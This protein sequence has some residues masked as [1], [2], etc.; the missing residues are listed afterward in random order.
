MPTFEVVSYPSGVV[1]ARL[2]PGEELIQ[3]VTDL[4]AKLS[5]KSGIVVAIGGLSS[6]EL[7]VYRGG[8]Y[9][10]ESYEVKQGETI[11]L[12]SAMGSIAIGDDGK[13]SVHIHA[14][15][16]LPDHRTSAGHLLR[17]TVSPLVEVF[18]I[19]LSAMLKRT[20]DP[21]IGLSALTA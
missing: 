19:G 9:D 6:V 7:G 15:V 5:V 21:S 10:V 17:A 8:R 13:P 3:A 16:S 11:E 20:V 14:T 2:Q 1:I 18:I 4:A 12:T